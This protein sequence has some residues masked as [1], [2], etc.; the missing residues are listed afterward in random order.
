MSPTR[1]RTLRAVPQ[2]IR[3]IPFPCSRGPCQQSVSGREDR[4]YF[5]SGAACPAPVTAGGGFLVSSFEL[6]W[7]NAFIGS[8]A[9]AALN[10][11]LSSGLGLLSHPARPRDNRA[12]TKSGSQSRIAGPSSNYGTFTG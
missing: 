4:S 6:P 7:G 8:F 5:F 2:G 12:T 10:R 1:G 3:L 9:D 11:G